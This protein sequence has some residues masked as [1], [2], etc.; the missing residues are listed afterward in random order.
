MR[1]L[2]Q[3]EA[4]LKAGIDPQF[5]VEELR[6][7]FVELRRMGQERLALLRELAKL[8]RKAAVIGPEERDGD[9]DRYLHDLEK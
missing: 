9:W 8:R 4:L 5:S 6:G 3:V 7:I 1:N 2:D